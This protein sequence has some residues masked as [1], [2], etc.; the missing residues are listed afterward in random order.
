MSVRYTNF[1]GT[2]LQLLFFPLSVLLACRSV[3]HTYTVPEEVRKRVFDPLGA[4][5]AHVGDRNQ[6]L[7]KSSQ[8][9]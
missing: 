3:Y 7:K 6:I 8:C 1:K 9:S 5:V 2:K 4:G